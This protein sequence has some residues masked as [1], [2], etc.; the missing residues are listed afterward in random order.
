MFFDEIFV[1]TRFWI[2]F[3]FFIVTFFHL[4]NR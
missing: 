1:M 3:F 4:F 2:S